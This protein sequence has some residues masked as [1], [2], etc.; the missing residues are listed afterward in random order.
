M[1][2]GERKKRAHI[3]IINYQLTKRNNGFSPRGAKRNNLNYKS[4]I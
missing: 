2:K 4:K 3:S 1:E